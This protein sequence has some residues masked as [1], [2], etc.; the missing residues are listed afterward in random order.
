TGQ[1]TWRVLEELSTESGQGKVWKV[2]LSEGLNPIERM[3]GALTRERSS[4]NREVREGAKREFEVAF[5]DFIHG[6]SNLGALKVIKNRGVDEAARLRMEASVYGT[7]ADPHSIVVR[8][9]NLA[10]DWIITEYQPNK[11]WKIASL[12]L[13]GRRLKVLGQFVRL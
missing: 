9:L 13:R 4:S 1:Y 5:A 3:F 11:H 12:N 10:D 6:R 8:D 7:I 2:A